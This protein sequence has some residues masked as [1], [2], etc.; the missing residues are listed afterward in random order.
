MFG[1][2]CYPNL[3]ATAPHKL[4]P[5]SAACIFLGYPVD[6]KGYRCYNPEINRV[7]VSCHIYFNE[8]IIPFRSR[9]S[10]TTV[11]RPE[12]PPSV[13]LLLAPCRLAASRTPTSPRCSSPTW[14]NATL[15]PGYVAATTPGISTSPQRSMMATPSA[16]TPPSPVVYDD[17]PALQPL[18]S[19]QQS[20]PAPP[21]QEFATVASTTPAPPEPPSPPLA[22][23]PHPMVTRARDGITKPNSRYAAVA[24][25]STVPTSVCVVL[26]DDA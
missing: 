13:E 16:A 3:A 24:E 5:Q 17:T 6:T 7:I 12:P 11:T 10:P 19:P 25:L 1:C 23:L 2:F 21:S 26:R 18:A 9:T 20:P 15:P 14:G 8:E 22:P 4:S